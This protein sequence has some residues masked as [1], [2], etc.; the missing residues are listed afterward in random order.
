MKRT[1]STFWDWSNVDRTE[2]F[3]KI[4]RL[5]TQRK[6]VPRDAFLDELEV[7]RATFK[8]DLEYLRDRMHMP[9]VFDR[10]LG[11]YRIDEEASTA[12]LYQL[13]GLWFSSDEIHALLTM[14]HMLER[15]QPGLLGPQLRPL[16]E[17]IRRILESGTLAPVKSAIVFASCPSACGRL[18]PP[19]SRQSQP[20]C[21]RGTG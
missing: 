21:C 15:L 12:H 19:P 5:L 13:P 6:F 3:Y 10:D 2:R 7:S 16:R 4:H 8:R 20:L 18:K 9:I 1:G 17:M 14:E 11:G